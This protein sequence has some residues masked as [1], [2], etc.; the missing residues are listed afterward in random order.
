M[1]SISVPNLK[2]PASI[3]PDILGGPKIP[4]MWKIWRVG[5]VHLVVLAFVLRATTIKKVV[6]F[7]RKKNCTPNKI[8]A[9][10]Y[11]WA[12]QTHGV[13]MTWCYRPFLLNMFTMFVCRS[14][15]SMSQN[16]GS[17]RSSRRSKMSNSLFTFSGS[18]GSAW[19]HRLHSIQGGQKNLHNFL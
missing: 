9:Y 8:L 17:I 12:I 18:D 7:L 3:D 1:P 16:L 19:V 11:D 14:V 13:Y 15:F 10:A 2:F 4:K 6:D 5:V